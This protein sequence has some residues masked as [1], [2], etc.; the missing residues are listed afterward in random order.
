LIAAPVSVAFAAQHNYPLLGMMSLF[1][2]WNGVFAGMAAVLL[3]HKLNAAFLTAW[4][5]MAAFFGFAALTR[6]VAAVIR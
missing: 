6:L 2:F 1:Y 5:E 4:D 3:R